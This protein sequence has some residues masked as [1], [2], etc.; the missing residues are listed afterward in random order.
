MPNETL[1][2]LCTRREADGLFATIPQDG[3]SP[4]IRLRELGQESR[5]SCATSARMLLHVSLSFRWQKT[6][7]RSAQTMTL[8]LLSENDAFW[9]RI[10]TTP[11]PTQ[12]ADARAPQL[13]AAEPA[14][15]V[16]IAQVED[17]VDEQGPLA[18]LPAC[19]ST[20]RRRSSGC[21][22]CGER[23]TC[24]NSLCAREPQRFLCSTRVPGLP[25]LNVKT[26][27]NR[28]AASTKQVLGQP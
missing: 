14:V 7:T 16:V 6:A 25:K 8:L 17:R 13:C 5:P 1:I 20:H 9:L 22:V 15:A 2:V 11:A 3:K 4:T 21:C 27:C 28:S 18:R 19:G 26:S 10:P 24:G 23:E 12:A